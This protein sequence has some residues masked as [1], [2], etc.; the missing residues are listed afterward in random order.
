MRKS[1]IALFCV[2]VLFFAFT[3][4][5]PIAQ[6]TATH[7]G[8]RIVLS[9]TEF[10]ALGNNNGNS[11]GGSGNVRHGITEPPILC[12]EYTGSN[13][14]LDFNHIIVP[15][16]LTWIFSAH[17]YNNVDLGF[18]FV[19]EAGSEVNGKFENGIKIVVKKEYGLQEFRY[20]FWYGVD[21]HYDHIDIR[22]PYAWNWTESAERNGTYTPP[23]GCS[24][25]TSTDNINIGTIENRFN[26]NPN[27]AT[28]MGDTYNCHNIKSY[29]L[30]NQ[31]ITIVVGRNFQH[32]GSAAIWGQLGGQNACETNCTEIYFSIIVKVSEAKPYLDEAYRIVREKN[33]WN[34]RTQIPISWTAPNN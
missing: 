14:Y 29:A 31:H 23:Y 6:A 20:F 3:F 19:Y 4:T 18:F 2:F 32:L 30:D 8:N 27:F 7:D 34:F 22:T 33:G 9:Y 21:E 16:G 10:N 24:G 26:N 13:G 28:S 12:V 5:T 17:R 15:E 1:L 11:N 25:S